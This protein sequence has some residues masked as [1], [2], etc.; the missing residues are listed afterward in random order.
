MSSPPHRRTLSQRQISKSQGDQQW[1]EYDGTV[2]QC[3]SQ[4]SDSQSTITANSTLND[5]T[6]EP[7]KR[8]P[9]RPRKIVPPPLSPSIHQTQTSTNTR[10]RTKTQRYAPYD[11]RYDSQIPNQESTSSQSSRSV[12]SD[13]SSESSTITTSSTQSAHD[14]FLKA[15]IDASVNILDLPTDRLG[16]L[17]MLP[18]SISHIPKRILPLI[19][20]TYN[21]VLTKALHS[22][23]TEDEELAAFKKAL[24]LPAVIFTT[25]GHLSFAA[26]CTQKCRLILLDKWESFT[27][28]NLYR[29]GSISHGQ[30]GE[31]GATPEVV[32]R[33]LERVVEKHIL[34]GN[35]RKGMQSAT[36][37]TPIVASSPDTLQKLQA[38]HPTLLQANQNPTLRR[39][40]TAP[41]IE[42]ST[43]AISWAIRMAA[44]GA[45]HGLDKLRVEHLKEVFVYDESQA[46]LA[47]LTELCNKIIN[48]TIDNRLLPYIRDSE[49]IAAKKGDSDVRPIVICGVLRKIALSAARR[50]LNFEKSPV[51]NYQH[52]L[53]RG[54]AEKVLLQM[55]TATELNESMNTVVLDATNAFNSASRN[56]AILSV[57]RHFPAMMPIVHALYGTPAT[58]WYGGM[59]S[60]P[61]KVTAEVG[62]QQGCV[63]GSWL[64]CLS[65]QSLVDLIADELGEDGM[66]FFYID[67]GN[68]VA[69]YEASLRAFQL[70][71]EKGPV[72]G[73]H[74]KWHAARYIQIHVIALVL[75]DE[76]ALLAA[77]HATAPAR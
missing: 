55:R 49:I 23:D 1:A 67:D 73:Y 59:D 61:Q 52:G 21:H 5:P 39:D 25:N 56:K 45:K 17:S 10:I 51:F 60:G 15:N 29:S 66:P 2:T 28:G 69:S 75:Q 64:Y 12:A 71:K 30:E 77:L 36:D 68:L 48:N 43:D 33:R 63:L 27:L 32:Q 54:G 22:R 41:P 40:T 20:K 72:C 9:G 46:L 44:K 74:I 42:L 26:D 58:I 38:K 3:S 18:N 37:Y 11:P 70:I 19:R 6:P 65:L 62:F 8:K 31:D 50:T 57:E 35:L 34:A 4:P 7:T 14:Y 13:T 53:E 76:S 47:L 24:L 16:I